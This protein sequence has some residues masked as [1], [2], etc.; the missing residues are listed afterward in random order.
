M[1]ETVRQG[2][3]GIQ[4]L[5]HKRSLLKPGSKGNTTALYLQQRNK[6]T[7]YKITRKA[8]HAKKHRILNML[9]RQ[10]QKLCSTGE[11]KNNGDVY[12]RQMFLFHP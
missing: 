6:L 10:A 9:T 2:R 3:L 4:K 8:K 1:W 11:R 12:P 7:M 5:D